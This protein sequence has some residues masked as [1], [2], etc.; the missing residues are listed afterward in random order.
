MNGYTGN[1]TLDGGAGS[2]TAQYSGNRIGYTLTSVPGGYTVT[3][4]NTVDGDDGI[5]TLTNIEYLAFA[6]V[7]LHLEPNRVPTGT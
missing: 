5:D 2:D 3:D 6:D 1:D 4:T 7:S